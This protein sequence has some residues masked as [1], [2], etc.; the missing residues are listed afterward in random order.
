MRDWYF[1]GLVD[2]MSA[3]KWGI[4]KID[5]IIQSDNMGINI[6]KAESEDA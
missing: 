3:Q 4:S 6:R 5:G 2:P 1:F